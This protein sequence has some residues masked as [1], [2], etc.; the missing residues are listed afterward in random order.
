MGSLPRL[1]RTIG[2]DTSA[3]LWLILVALLLTWIMLNVRGLQGNQDDQE[4]LTV[5]E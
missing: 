1:Q 5:L 2:Q 3:M 4:F